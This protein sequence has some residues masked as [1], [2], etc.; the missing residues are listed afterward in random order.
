MNESFFTV[1]G[2]ST[3]NDET[4]FASYRAGEDT[5]ND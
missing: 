1:Y 3:V 4:S 2:G 5:L